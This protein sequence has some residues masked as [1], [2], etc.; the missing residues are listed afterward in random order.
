[1][2]S[3]S[4]QFTDL[5][6]A[7]SAAQMNIGNAL[8]EKRNPHFNSTY[9]D[10]SSF[11]EASRQALFDNGLSI[12]QHPEIYEGKDIL[13]TIISHKS[14]QW[15]ESSMPIKCSKQ[16]AQGFGSA[17]TYAKRQA[18]A[19]ILAIATEDDDGNE[20][21]AN[22]FVPK[23]TPVPVTLTKAHLATITDETKGH[24]YII[25]MILSHY[26]VARMSDIPIEYFQEIMAGIQNT[27]KT[28]VQ[29]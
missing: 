24:E 14:G 15:E 23:P 4:E 18:L 11:I 5:F 1:M 6:A 20:A 27:K 21:C 2:V 22:K 29:E 16:D 12:R 8:K 10:L 25:E 9:A 13:T 26:K 3:R 19:A 7:L 17:L 28:L